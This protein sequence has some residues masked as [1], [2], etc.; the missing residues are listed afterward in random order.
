MLLRILTFSILVIQCSMA[1]ASEP[2]L[3]RLA[4]WVSPDRQTEFETVYER[5]VLPIL[6]KHGFR[7]SSEVGHPTI[8]S[9]FSRMFE[10]ENPSEGSRKGMELAG[11]PAWAATMKELAVTFG[12]ARPWDG[13]IRHTAMP[14]RAPAGRG[15]DSVV[16]AGSPVPAG[17]GKGHW[18][19]YDVDALLHIQDREDNL[20]FGS[21]GGA[22]RFDGLT[23]TRFDVIQPH[24][25]IVEIFEDRSGQIW[26]GGYFG[27]I[28]YDPSADPLPM[29][30]TSPRS[31]QYAADGAIH[32]TP[33]SADVFTKFTQMNRLV[34]TIIQDRRGD[35]WLGGS[36]VRRYDGKTFRT[37]TVDDGLALISVRRIFEDHSGNLWF[38][39]WEDAGITRYDGRNWR[40]FTSL[41]GLPDNTVNGIGQDK[42]GI[43]WLS[44]AK[45]LSRYDGTRWSNV[46]DLSGRILQDRQGNLLIDGQNGLSR[47]DGTRWTAHAQDS[48]AGSPGRLR[49]QDREGHLWFSL[50]RTS[51]SS[52]SRYGGATF[53]TFTTEDGLGADN[54]MSIFQ[55][56]RG[57][58]WFGTRDGG[59]SRYDGK[60]F[61]TFTDDDGLA[62]NRVNAIFQDR[63]GDLWFGTM[64]GVSR[65]DGHTM[66]TFTTDDGLPND[67]TFS[68]FQDSSGDHWFGTGSGVTRY[69]G[70]T[71]TSFS[72]AEGVTLGRGGE[73]FQDRSGDLWFCDSESGGGDPGAIRYDG[74]RFTPLTTEDGLISNRVVS[75]LQDR[76]GTYWYG[77]PGYGLSHFSPTEGTSGRGNWSTLTAEDGLASNYVHSIYEDRNGHIWFSPK[78]N[79]KLDH[80]QRGQPLRR[81]GDPDTD[82]RGRSRGQ[83]GH[84]RLPGS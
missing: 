57:D 8:A 23:W 74:K 52:V 36:G 46:S 82:A 43:L 60:T 30:S 22:I 48:G 45:G 83:P 51:G 81:A 4:F 12:N 49:L 33:T 56:R 35:L 42:N 70:E 18:Q 55:D 27:V 79:A 67:A 62:G 61:T 76:T 15:T 68:I 16:G 53:S 19:T 13:A 34:E 64:G 40:T 24:N 72:H 59:V 38:G 5:D 21:K 80:R 37:F 41:D 14:H 32:D 9:V 50:S 84:R 6:H 58:L 54:V 26:F 17:H 10:F 78:G 25:S 71:F 66:T 1:N 73:I 28:R 29:G 47:N 77:T 31:I 63:S 2:T 39:Y 11:D 3:A 44:T 75:M 20:W 65:F 7:E 69:D